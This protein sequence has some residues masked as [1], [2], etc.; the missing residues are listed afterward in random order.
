ML[1]SLN[2]QAQE[3][4]IDR[5]KQAK[6]QFLQL[7]T[8]GEDNY[9]FLKYNGRW[10]QNETGFLIGMGTLDMYLSNLRAR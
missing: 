9:E 7:M 5:V 1:L 8:Y 3:C 2:C 10:E 6:N 4:L